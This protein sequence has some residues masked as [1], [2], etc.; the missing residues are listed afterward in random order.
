MSSW[1]W[2]FAVEDACADRCEPPGAEVL[3]NEHGTIEIRKGNAVAMP[4]MPAMPAMPAMPKMPK[5][6]KVPEVPQP[7]EN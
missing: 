3:T 2:Q 1:H 6:P 4:P 5:L 7:T